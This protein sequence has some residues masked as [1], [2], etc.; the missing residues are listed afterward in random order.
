[1][2]YL[3]QTMNDAELS[4]F[5]TLPMTLQNRRVQVIVLPDEDNIQEKPKG[6]LKLGFMPEPPLPD[7]FFDPL[8]EKDLQVSYSHKIRFRTKYVF[9]RYIRKEGY[10]VCLQK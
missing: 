10:V 7:S 5:L 9:A 3:R 2:E 8:P 4:K 1:M 6:K